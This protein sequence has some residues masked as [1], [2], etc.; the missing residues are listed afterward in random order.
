M[1]KWLQYRLVIT[2]SVSK[3]CRIAR[4]RLVEPNEVLK[5]SQF[6]S[7]FG[8]V[9]ALIPNVVFILIYVRIALPVHLFSHSHV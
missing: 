6:R 7:S 9:T 8:E 4:T 3:F 5:S 1:G 2:S